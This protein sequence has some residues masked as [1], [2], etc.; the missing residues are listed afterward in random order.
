MELEGGRT[1]Y[2]VGEDAGVLSMEGGS[3]RGEKLEGGREAGRVEGGK[4]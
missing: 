1:D 3:R 4:Q 2:V